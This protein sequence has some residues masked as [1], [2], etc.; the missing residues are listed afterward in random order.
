MSV[1]LLL[2]NIA[3]QSKKRMWIGYIPMDSGLMA[4]G[5]LTGDGIYDPAQLT[6]EVFDFNIMKYGI[7]A[8]VLIEM[9]PQVFHTY[10]VYVPDGGFTCIILPEGWKAT[11]DNGNGGEVT[12]TEGNDVNGQLAQDG[13]MIK[14]KINGVQYYMYG[15]MFNVGGTIK[16]HISAI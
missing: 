4:G 9:D 5:D 10:D 3:Q 8:N 2:N 12:F 7:D 15:M 14:E 11:F 6:Q 13:M 16:L 1:K